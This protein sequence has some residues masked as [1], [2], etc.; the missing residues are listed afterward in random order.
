MCQDEMR[1]A[2]DMMV[3]INMTWRDETWY[4]DGMYHSMTWDEVWRMMWHDGMCHIMTWYDMICACHCY[5]DRGNDVAAVTVILVLM[6]L[7]HWV[8]A[9]AIVVV[10]WLQ[11]WHYSHIGVAAVMIT[12]HD[13]GWSHEIYHNMAREMRYIWHNMM[14][15]EHGCIITW[16]MRWDMMGCVITWHDEMR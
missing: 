8:A 10:M 15:Y 12:Q 14:W 4:H 9:V 3:W 13:M 11:T 7:E 16:T 5:N 2:S 6:S 1:Y